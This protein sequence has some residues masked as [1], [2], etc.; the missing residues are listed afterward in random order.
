MKYCCL[1]DAGGNNK[2]LV[3]TREKKNIKISKKKK[4]D[5][6]KYQRP[7]ERSKK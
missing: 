5:N 3:Q 7:N 2:I 4:N 6:A 1:L